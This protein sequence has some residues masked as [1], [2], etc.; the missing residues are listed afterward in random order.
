MVRSGTLRC[1]LQPRCK[2]KLRCGGDHGRTQ[3][4]LLEREARSPSSA[5]A[6]TLLNSRRPAVI[7]GTFPALP[8]ECRQTPRTARTLSPCAAARYG[9]RPRGDPRPSMNPAVCGKF[10]SSVRSSPSRGRSHRTNT[11]PRWHPRLRSCMMSPHP[12]STRCMDTAGSLSRF[13]AP[14]SSIYRACSIRRSSGVA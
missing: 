2:R 14:P 10:L 4:G 7:L 5:P 9:R 6:T 11:S 3:R 13:H 12:F 8:S 1:T